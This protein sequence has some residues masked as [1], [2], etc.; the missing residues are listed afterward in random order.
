MVQ[1]ARFFSAHIPTGDG[2]YSR[3]I[4]FGVGSGMGKED[5]PSDFRAV[6]VFVYVTVNLFNR[7]DNPGSSVSRSSIPATLP[8]KIFGCVCVGRWGTLPLEKL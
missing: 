7:L 8:F 4:R 1:R 3:G 6:K 2:C 5:V